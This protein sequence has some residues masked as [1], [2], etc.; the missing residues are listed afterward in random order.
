MRKPLPVVLIIVDHTDL[1]PVKLQKP[2]AGL[3]RHPKVPRCIHGQVRFV[4]NRADPVR[5]VNLLKRPRIIAPVLRH[6]E[7]LVDIGRKFRPH[8]FMQRT[9]LNGI[10][11]HLLLAQSNPVPRIQLVEIGKQ[12]RRNHHRFRIRSIFRIF[13]PRE[14]MQHKFLH[15]MLLSGQ[16]L[17]IGGLHHII[18][19]PGI[20]HR[21]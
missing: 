7:R 8:V 1:F 15:G 16:P 11:C 9:L 18:E 12:S 5:P 4:R 13:V 19:I 14:E 20:P 6:L 21:G 2:D 10:P 3:V 17:C